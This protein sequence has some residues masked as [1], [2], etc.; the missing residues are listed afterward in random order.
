MGRDIERF[1]SGRTRVP[2]VSPKRILSLAIALTV[3]AG[4]SSGS[5]LRAGAAQQTPTDVAISPLAL[6]QINALAREKAS[7]TGPQR[8]IDSQLLYAIKMGRGE[9]IAAGVSTLDVTLPNGDRGRLTIDV[10]TNAVSD[11]FYEQ[12]R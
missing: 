7:R 12:L 3:L 4:G 5:R 6:A 8:K 2:H 1:R 11:L 10:S 9:Q